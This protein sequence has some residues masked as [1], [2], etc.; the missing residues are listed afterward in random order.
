[1]RPRLDIVL[2]LLVAALLAAFLVAISL[3][4]QSNHPTVTLVNPT[5]ASLDG[6]ALPTGIVAPPFTLADQYGRRVSLAQEHGHVTVLAFLYTTCG[7]ACVLIA[8]QIRG[9]L[10]ELASPV[11]VLLI[12]AD[13]VA[14]TPARVSRFLAEVS[15]SGRVHYLS[16]PPA[17]MRRI[18]KQYRVTPASA[19]RKA[20]ARS[21]AVML[22]DGRG[23]ERDLF[24]QEQLT[25]ESL[26]HDIRALQAG[27]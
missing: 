1:V 21:A 9:A 16:G 23:R 26:A 4:G 11:P 5:A 19:G 18:W 8:Q 10:D 25:P 15:L 14:D 17:Q 20:F 24:E 3:R 13:P 12:S 27:A 22:V 2:A 7:A 6:A